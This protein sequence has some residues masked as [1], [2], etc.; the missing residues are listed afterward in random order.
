MRGHQFALIRCSDCHV[1]AADQ[2]FSPT[3]NVGAPAFVQIANHGHPTERSL[4]KFIRRTHWDGQTIPITMPALK[5]T[6]RET[7]DLARYIMSLRQD[8][9]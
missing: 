1:V 5:L 9:R 8:T 4:E 3:M 2:N 6:R 7:V